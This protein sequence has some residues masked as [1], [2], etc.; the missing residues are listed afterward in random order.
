M[1]DKQETR[2]ICNIVDDSTRIRYKIIYRRSAN[3]YEIWSQFYDDSGKLHRNRITSNEA[4][5]VEGDCEKTIAYVKEH[6]VAQHINIYDERLK[7]QK[8]KTKGYVKKDFSKD[9]YKETHFERRGCKDLDQL[10]C[11]WQQAQADESEESWQLTRGSAINITREHF[12][13]DGIIDN[14]IFQQEDRKILF[15][16]SEANDDAYSAK[17]KVSPSTIDDYINY[18]ISRHDDWKGKMR[19]RL[20]EIY[21]VICHKDRYSLA[22]PDAALHFSVMDINKRGG[23]AL[24]GNDNHIEH[25]CKVYASFIRE[26]IEIINPDIVAIVGTNLFR[27]N[28]HGK[29]LG[30]ITDG[31]REYF[32]IKEKKVPILSIWQTS[33]YQSKC[34]VAKGYEDNKIIG[35][36][37]S[38]VLHEM[39]R[40]NL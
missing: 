11:L 4:L 12:R 24:I 20:S 35:K 6:L 29:Y 26:E 36:Q 40:Y 5:A 30:A 31:G 9:T 37:V 38:R 14:D 13:R 18:Y 32:I 22:N 27:A 34:S 7:A 10:F 3:R 39:E 2:K 23:G 8:V 28:L 19:E 33:Y 1:A 21:K 15:I 25:Y 16:S 17:I